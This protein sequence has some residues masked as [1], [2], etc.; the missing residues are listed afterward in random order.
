[1][2]GYTYIPRVPNLCSLPMLLIHPHFHKQKNWIDSL[3]V[4]QVVL[5]FQTANAQL[6]MQKKTHT[7]KINVV[8]P[9]I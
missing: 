5:G 3:A 8:P 9:F 6:K 2:E 7:Q 4:A 1:M